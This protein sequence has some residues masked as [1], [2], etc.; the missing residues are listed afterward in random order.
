MCY[1][2]SSSNKDYQTCPSGFDRCINTA[3]DGVAAYTCGK[4]SAMDL[5]GLAADGCKTVGS[6]KY[7]SC[8]CDK[9]IP[10]TSSGCSDSSMIKNSINLHVLKKSNKFTNKVIN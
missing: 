4:Q 6:I 9:C 3:T 5:V 10:E 1:V 7:C 2:G 8:S